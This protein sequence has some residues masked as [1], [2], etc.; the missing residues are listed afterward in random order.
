[1]QNQFY[2]CQF[3]KRLKWN[4]LLISGGEDTHW[5]LGSKSNYDIE[6]ISLF[7]VLTWKKERYWSCNSSLLEVFFSRLETIFLTEW[8]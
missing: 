5:F 3:A 1:M 6:E 2:Y 8:T 4:N 7:H